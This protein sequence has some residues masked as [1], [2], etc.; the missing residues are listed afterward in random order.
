MKPEEGV[1]QKGLDAIK[2]RQPRATEFLEEM[3]M[4]PLTTGYYR[5]VSGRIRHCVVH[6]AGSG[7]NW[8]IRQS[9]ASALGREMKNFP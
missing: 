1:G 8:R 5:A 9:Q 7:V 2:A 3:A 4:V 6:G